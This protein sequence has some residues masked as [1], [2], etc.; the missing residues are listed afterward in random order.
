VICL[1]FSFLSNLNQCENA[2]TERINEERNSV[3]WLTSR[4]VL[5][6]ECRASLSLRDG[7]LE[8]MVIVGA[9]MQSQQW[10]PRYLHFP[11]HFQLNVT[12]AIG[13]FG[14]EL[15]RWVLVSGHSR[16]GSSLTSLP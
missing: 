3:R 13:R 12:H 5:T 8:S 9:S 16:A 10:R 1:A 7:G 4:R 11:R 6:I 15:V 14:G 2:R